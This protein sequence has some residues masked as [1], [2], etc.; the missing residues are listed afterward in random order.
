[1]PG[2]SVDVL[3]QLPVAGVKDSSGEAERL[4]LECDALPTGVYTGSPAL[5]QLAAA[6]GCSGAILGLANVDPDGCSRAWAGDGA[7]KRDLLSVHP[8]QSLPRLVG[9][10]RTLCVPPGTNPGPRLA[11]TSR[12]PRRL[13]PN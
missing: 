3:G 13:P 11:L 7:V 1:M 9:L 12:D 2:L 4:L 6:T 10:N 5:V 8:G